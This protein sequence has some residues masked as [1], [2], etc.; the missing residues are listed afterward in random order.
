MRNPAAVAQ[1]DQE[2]AYAA[3]FSRNLGPCADCNVFSVCTS[4]RLPD[5]RRLVAIFNH[6]PACPNG[7]ER[8][9]DIYVTEAPPNTGGPTR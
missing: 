6:E 9:F 7:R 2:D 4:E 8:V 3:E 5:G 1:Q